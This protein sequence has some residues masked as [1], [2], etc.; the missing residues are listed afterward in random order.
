MYVHL[1]TDLKIH[2]EK[3]KKK[4]TLIE[5]KGETDKPTIKL[6]TLTLPSQ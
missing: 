5:L 4:K 6:E 3:E 1:M 2:Q